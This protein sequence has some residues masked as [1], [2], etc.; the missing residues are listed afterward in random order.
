MTAVNVVRRSARVAA[1]LVLQVAGFVLQWLPRSPRIIAIGCYRNA[2]ADNSKYLY[3]DLLR[4]RPDLR[5]VWISGLRQTVAHVRSRGGEAHHRWSPMGLYIAI[6]AR[7]WF[8]SAYVHEVNAYFARGA[9]VTNLW[10]G[11]PMKKIEFDIDSG[12]TGRLF[13][14]PTFAERFS[15]FPGVFRRADYLACPSA[16]LATGLFSRAFRI[17]VERCIAATPPRILPL[18]CDEEQFQD[19]VAW[20]DAP[21]RHAVAELRGYAAYHV[22]MPT[23]RDTRPDFLAELVPHLAELSAL[24]SRRNEAFVM[25][26]HANTPGAILE[27]FARWPNIVVVDPRADAYPIMRGATTLITDYSSVVFDYLFLNRRILFF[28]FDLDQYAAADRGL[29][30][31]YDEVTPGPRARSIGELLRLLP[32]PDGEPWPSKRAALLTRF[33]GHELPPPVRLLV[34]R[35]VAPRPHRSR[36]RRPG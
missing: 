36:E 10:H 16:A 6:R 30:F 19:L 12:P 21:T 15:I 31:A 18:L 33:Y 23:W 7:Y 14:S 34:E 2:F 26:P 28:A 9:T 4:S 1:G 13:H 5:V 22:Y 27:E 3:I 8:V 11:I 20:C 25:K 24:M 29:Y 32:E 17:P 35:F